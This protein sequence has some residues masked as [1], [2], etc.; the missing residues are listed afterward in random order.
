MNTMPLTPNRSHR[1]VA[2]VAVATALLAAACGGASE[3]REPGPGEAAPALAVTTDT[4][5]DT[6]LA[7]TFEAGGVVRARMTATIAARVLAPVVEVSV[8]AGDRVRRGATLVTL[9]GREMRAHVARGR[10][11][12]EAADAAASAA[13]SHTAA[14]DAGLRLA[15]ATYDR[16]SGLHEKRSATSQ[17]LDQATAGLRAAEAQ[18]AAARSQS[19]AA[20]AARDAARAGADVTDIGLSYAVLTAPFDGIVAARSTDP[21]SLATP[22]A[23][24][25]VL[26]AAGPVRLEVTV[27]EARGGGLTIGQSV[28][29]RIDGD[30]DTYLAGTIAEIGRVDPASHSF[31][32]KIDL[33][34]RPAGRTGVFGRARFPGPAR[35]ALTV[36]ASS[37]VRRGQLAFVY[38][39]DD[40]VRARL[41]PV[42]PGPAVGDRAE[43]LAGLSAGDVVVAS[44]PAAL[45]DGGRVIVNGAPRAAASGGGR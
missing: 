5:T 27:D 33:P 26:E 2:A 8:R 23:P 21:G 31:V 15:R 44:P 37:L 36:A 22:G 1:Q 43:V 35:R 19:L 17:E 7:S 4:A 3:P 14:A 40:E 20:N 41:R 6:D 39:V 32:V 13:A 24:L 18:L 45:R 42:T 9:D 29:V 25:L 30:G 28:A 34:D 10:A 16:I 38:V 11:S 12:L